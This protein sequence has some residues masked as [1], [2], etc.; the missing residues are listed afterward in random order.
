[1]RV[2][3]ALAGALAT[4]CAGTTASVVRTTATPLPPVPAPPSPVPIAGDAPV[5][6]PPPGPT[7]GDAPVPAPPPGPTAAVSP[8]V[9]GMPPAVTPVT[10]PP[11]PLVVALTGD[12]Q[13]IRS[14]AQH[15]PMEDVARLL[16]A[17]DLTIV[18]LET[19]VAAPDE[20][21]RPPIDKEFVF[22]SPPE[23]LTQLREAGV[24]VVALA[25]DHAWD[26]GHRGVVATVRHATDSGI[27]PVGAGA[28][29]AAAYEPVW[30]DVGARR[31]GIVSLTRVPCDWSR[32]P[33]ARRPEIA[34]GCDRFAPLARGSV[35]RAA[36]D[37]DVTIVMLHAGTEMAD[38][39]D[40]ALRAA[41]ASY[42]AAGADVV[43]VS[44][45]HVVQGIEILDGAVVLWST[46]NFTFANRGG[47]TARSALFEVAL[48]PGTGRP[49]TV[50][51]RPV[52]LPSGITRPAPFPEATRVLEEISARSV[53]G[54]VGFDG[55]LRPDPAPSPCDP[56]TG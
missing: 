35:V 2:R 4:A 46:G 51:V 40:E 16:S 12:V 55:V 26:H 56:V 53:G 13:M 30:L 39:P 9:P 50:T 3:G 20:V 23:T 14:M 29:I 24:D 27:V 1:M 52:V 45:P 42:V 8:G 44:H 34:W 47:R 43:S 37:A 31:V 15:H 6:A 36:R 22:R 28:G 38:C 19:V 7:A 11:R 49:P 48:D 21:G 10:V 54:R 25:N 5:P 33:A 18:N 41:V 17:A 32:D